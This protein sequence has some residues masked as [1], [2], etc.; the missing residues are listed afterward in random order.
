MSPD[1]GGSFFRTARNVRTAFDSEEVA[2]LLSQTSEERVRILQAR[3]EAY[4][5]ENLPKAI[6]SKKTLQDY[7]S[8][9]YVLMATSSVMDLED[10][11]D[12]AQFLVN[13]KL[14]MG[15]E[16]SF[17]KSVEGIVMGAYPAGV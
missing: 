16:T 10:P 4:I 14:Y 12:F 5:G 9:P 17:G 3:L 2:G 7:R 15:L 8:N 13:N 1:D 11:Q 6:A